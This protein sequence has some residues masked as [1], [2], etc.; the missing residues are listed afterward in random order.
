MVERPVEHPAEIMILN[1]PTGMW[2]GFL[3]K[4]GFEKVLDL[5]L[6]A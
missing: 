3:S 6:P 4:M 1:S 2:A 5:L